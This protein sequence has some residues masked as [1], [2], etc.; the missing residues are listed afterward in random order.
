MI[1]VGDIMTPNPKTLSPHHAVSTALRLMLEGG[2]HHI[3]I[4]EEGRLVG[5][6]HADHI[7]S[8]LGM[9]TLPTMAPSSPNLWENIP[10]RAVMSEVKHTATPDMPIDRLV[11]LMRRHALTGVPVMSGDRLVGIVTVTDVLSVTRQLLSLFHERPVPPA[12]SFVGKSGSGKTTLI[13]RL[14]P[15]L[16]ERGYRVGVVK[17]HHRPTWIDQEGKD[18]WRYARVGATPVSIVSQVQTAVFLQTNN[19]LPLD[20]V[21]ARFFRDVD[22]VLIEGYRWADKPKIE[23]HRRERSQELLCRPEELLAL[24]SDQ[25]WELPC[26]QFRPGDIEAIATFV[27]THVIRGQG[28]AA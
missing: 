27:E 11:D 26:P 16:Q 28:G 1:R 5:I 25:E 7:R 8:G 14:V 6:V 15:V 13:E 9:V 21:I 4:L 20:L 19:E 24:V 17:H 12:V 3:P 22:V 2:F 18:T 10:L 23:V